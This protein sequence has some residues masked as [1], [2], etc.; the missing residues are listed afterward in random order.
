MV[1]DNHMC[2]EINILGLKEIYGQFRGLIQQRSKTKQLHS[3]SESKKKNSQ[4]KN[5]YVI[6]FDKMA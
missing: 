2:A 6:H 4:T 5:K 3:M 1:C